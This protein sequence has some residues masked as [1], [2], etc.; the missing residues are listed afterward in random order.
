M[1]HASGTGATFLTVYIQDPDQAIYQ[2]L[3]DTYLPLRDTVMKA[4]HHIWWNAQPC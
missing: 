1:T 3:V 2:R 4:T